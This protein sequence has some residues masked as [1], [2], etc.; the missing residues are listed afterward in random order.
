MPTEEDVFLQDILDHPD[1]DT[2]RLIYADW[3]DDHGRAER[4]EFIRLQIEL[5]RL[6]PSDPR[7]SVLELLERELLEEYGEEWAGLLPRVVVRRSFERGFLHGIELLAQGFSQLPAVFGWAPDVRSL[8]LTGPFRSGKPP[9]RLVAASPHLAQLTSLEISKGSYHVNDAAASILARS[10]H[11]GNLTSLSLHE[12][13]VGAAGVADIVISPHLG[14]L[15]AL[16]V[17]GY[18]HPFRHY[19][20]LEG[21]R[22]LAAL[23]LPSRLTSLRLAEC[24]IDDEACRMLAAAPGLAGLKT[25]DLTGNPISEAMKERL[26]ERFGDRLRI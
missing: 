17:S 16:S 7:R 13:H 10:P 6:P 19:S 4:G 23:T 12:N 15:V 5:A 18:G 22:V 14:R 3:L 1:D 9:M 8:H 11:L 25:L 26:R 20:G 2:P 21:V 24:G